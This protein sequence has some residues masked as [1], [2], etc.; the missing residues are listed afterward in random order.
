MFITVFLFIFSLLLFNHFFL[1][2]FFSEISMIHRLAPFLLSPI[3]FI[4]IKMSCCLYIFCIV[5]HSMYVSDFL[6]K[7]VL[8]IYSIIFF[9]FIFSWTL[10]SPASVVIGCL[11]WTL[12]PFSQL[13]FFKGNMSLWYL[14]F[15]AILLNLLFLY[16]RENGS[17]YAEIYL[18]PFLS[19]LI[20]EWGW[21]KV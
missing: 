7:F 16:A 14:L 20:F 11:L 21:E 17:F 4:I 10:F 19:F 15:I 1:F 2:F 5:F 12:L 3:S 18:V 13:F 8:F 9:I 6:V